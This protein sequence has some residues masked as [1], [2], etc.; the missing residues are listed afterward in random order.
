MWSMGLRAIE[1]H[2][3]RGLKQLS[4]LMLVVQGLS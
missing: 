4:E 1:E 3:V 2:E